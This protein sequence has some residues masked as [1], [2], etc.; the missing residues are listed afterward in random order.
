MMKLNII[1]SWIFMLMLVMLVFLILSVNEINF[2]LV[3]ILV[4]VLEEEILFCRSKC[5]MMCMKIRRV[6][7]KRCNIGCMEVCK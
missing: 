4:L 7:K 6:I 1:K 2:E 5:M 3:L